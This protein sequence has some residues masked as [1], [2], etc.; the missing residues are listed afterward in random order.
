VSKKH[1]L[2]LDK[3]DSLTMSKATVH[4]LMNTIF[5]EHHYDR[6]QHDYSGALQSGKSHKN[7]A[8][9]GA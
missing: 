3:L 4:F 8:K 7:K 1:S 6:G 2:G 5:P 9:N